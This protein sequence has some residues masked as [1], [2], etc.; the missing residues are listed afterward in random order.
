MK[1]TERQELI[2]AANIIRDWDP[3]GTVIELER[4]FF[5]LNDIPGTRYT[6]EWESIRRALNENESLSNAVIR[7]NLSRKNLARKG[8]WWW[9]PE[10]W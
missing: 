7:D 5:I 9:D 3:A 8:Y 10:M 2:H 6:E 1:R 4:T